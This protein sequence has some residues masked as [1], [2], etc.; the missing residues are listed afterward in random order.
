MFTG[1]DEWYDI[2]VV[3]PSDKERIM[4]ISTLETPIT[5]ESI[6]IGIWSEEENGMIENSENKHRFTYWM[7]L[8]KLHPIYSKD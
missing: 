6:K 5:E 2:R 7:Y 4:I 3:S 1:K 8:P